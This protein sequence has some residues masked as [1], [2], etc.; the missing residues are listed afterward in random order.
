[1]SPLEYSDVICSLVRSDLPDL[2]SR[3]MAIFMSLYTHKTFGPFTVRGIAEDL[4]FNKPAVTRSIDRL[5][6]LD[7]V[8]R[9]PDH[10]DRRSV[11]ISDTLQGLQFFRQIKVILREAART[12]RYNLRA[13]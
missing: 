11:W 13:T 6:E 9:V 3:Q 12:S 8:R 2:S 4:E 7:L 1:M 5:E 10:V